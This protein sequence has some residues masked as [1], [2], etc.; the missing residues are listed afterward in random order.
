[1]K[2]KAIYLLISMLVLAATVMAEELDDSSTSAPAGEMDSTDETTFP[3]NS[4]TTLQKVG[5]ASGMDQYRWYNQ[6]FCWTHTFS[7]PGA[8]LME[9]NLTI[10]AWDVDYAA[11]ERDYIKVDGVYVGDLNGSNNAWSKTTLP[12]DKTALDDGK[13][14]VCIDIDATRRGAAVTVD[15]SEMMV[16]W[17]YPPAP[18][19]A[20]ILLALALVSP[21]FVYLGVRKR[22]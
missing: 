22:K 13:I 6:D 21:A 12:F 4:F 2:N 17:D 3:S 14:T 11:G 10:R 7:Q 1:M 5:N 15:W 19:P 16:E 20:A 8:V 18:E 9:T